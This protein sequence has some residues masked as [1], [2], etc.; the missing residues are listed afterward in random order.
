M[1]CLGTLI[2]CSLKAYGRSWI[3]KLV[4][5]IMGVALTPSIP[6]NKPDN[7]PLYYVIPLRSLDPKPRPL[8]VHVRSCI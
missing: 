2:F 5:S 3:A 7:V 4:F 6:P 1:N 8:N